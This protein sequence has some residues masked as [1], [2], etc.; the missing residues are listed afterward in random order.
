MKLPQNRFNF[1]PNK[2]RR[3]AKI[4]KFLFHLVGAGVLAAGTVSLYHIGVKY[5]PVSSASDHKT[6]LSLWETKN[7]AEIIRLTESLLKKKPMDPYGLVFNGFAHFYTGVNQ[8]TT[9]DKISHIAASIT[10]LRRARLHAKPPLR[11]EVDYILGKAYYHKGLHYADLSARYML[12]SIE[13]KFVGQDSYEYL[14]LAFSNTGDYA[15]SLKY[16]LKA[17]ENNPSDLLFLTLAQT[18]YQLGDKAASEEYLM[19]AINKSQDAVLI[20]KA[21]FLLGDIYF[22]NKEYIKSEEQYLKVLEGR[23]Q[24]PDSHFHLGEI[25]AALG[26]MVKARASWRKALR[27]DPNHFGALR[28]L[29]N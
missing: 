29:Y 17:G 28:R 21:R 18:Y 6:I 23:P 4:V 27:I 7:Y 1:T 16:F 3:R 9:E 13:R 10:S 19:R 22:Q 14:G 25:Y 11:G 12:S 15:E 2:Q 20:E 8:T 5:L 24:N 26:D